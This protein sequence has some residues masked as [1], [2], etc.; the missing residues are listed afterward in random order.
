MKQKTNRQDIAKSNAKS[1]EMFPSQKPNSQWL[2]QWYWR[3]LQSCMVRFLRIEFLIQ[4]MHHH[5]RNLGFKFWLNYSH[6]LDIWRDYVLNITIVHTLLCE[7]NM[8]TITGHNMVTITGHNMVTITGHIMVTITGHI[9]SDIFQTAHILAVT[10][11]RD[12]TQIFWW[13][14]YLRRFEKNLKQLD[15]TH[16]VTIHIL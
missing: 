10:V 13:Y 16:S 1:V 15:Q 7:L 3:T 11:N 6:H 14:P 9:F 12:N 2:L 4:M 8:V 5:Q